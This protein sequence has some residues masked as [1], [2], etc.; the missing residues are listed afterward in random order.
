MIIAPV[1][2][3]PNDYYMVTAGLNVRTGAGIEYSIAFTLQKVDEVE[4]LSKNDSWY[5]IK[6]LE[7]VG[8][9]NSKYLKSTTATKINTAYRSGMDNSGLGILI[10]LGLVVF[11]WLLPIL[12]I[13]SSGKTTFSE[14]MAWL[15][16]VFFTSW[17]AF[18]FYMLLAPI[19]KKD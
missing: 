11:F 15:L 19:K 7:Q 14:K 3:F 10:I 5:K 18:I 1:M 17:F 6:Y 12:I 2:S 13:V 8:Y 9:A 4:L 16:A